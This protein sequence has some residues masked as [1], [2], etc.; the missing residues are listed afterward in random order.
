MSFH[1]VQPPKDEEQ[2]AEVGK[3]L[4]YAGVKLGLTLDVEGFLN[5]WASG[6]RVIVERDDSDEIVSMAFVACGRRWVRS[7]FTASLLDIRGNVDATLEF[8][9]TVCNA[10]GATHLFYEEPEVL[11]EGDGFRRYVVREHQLQ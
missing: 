2:F 7:D 1:V 10:L 5:A 3:E 9:K 8:V 11:E 4:Y 6:T